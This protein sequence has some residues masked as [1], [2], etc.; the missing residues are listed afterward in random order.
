MIKALLPDEPVKTE[1]EPW[2][3]VNIGYIGEDDIKV[4][5]FVVLDA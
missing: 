5:R 3:V 1:I 4:R 2:W